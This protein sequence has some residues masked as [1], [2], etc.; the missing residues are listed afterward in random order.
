[1]KYMC[2]LYSFLI[3]VLT[4][5]QLNKHF[6]C[7]FTIGFFYKRSYSIINVVCPT[8]TLWGNEFFSAANTAY[9]NKEIDL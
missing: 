7:I 9:T 4:F 1:M 2:I 5:R 3:M 8:V 6:I